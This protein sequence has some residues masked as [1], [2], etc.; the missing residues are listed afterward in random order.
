MPT[1]LAGSSPV[2][3]CIAQ[4]IASSGLVMTMTKASGAVLLDVLADALDDGGVGGDQVVA[5]H[6][7]LARD[8]G[9]D[10]HHVGTLDRGIVVGAGE[11]GV[12]ALD[13]AQLCGEIQ[14]LAGGHALGDVEQ[15]DVAQLLLRGQQG[16]ACRRSG[17]HR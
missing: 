12:E 8:A 15:H 1:T 2:T 13:R 16:Q 4:T 10:D 3:F 11:R 6:A 5:A 7:R 17:R 9:G 14:R